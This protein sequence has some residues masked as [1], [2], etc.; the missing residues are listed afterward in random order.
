MARMRIEADRY[1]KRNSPLSEMVLEN[2]ILLSFLS[3]YNLIMICYRWGTVQE[4]STVIVLFL[5]SDIVTS[6]LLW[7]QKIAQAFAFQADCGGAGFY[8]H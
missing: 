4:D 2:S 5:L 1:R 7:P 8:Q 6:V 3:L